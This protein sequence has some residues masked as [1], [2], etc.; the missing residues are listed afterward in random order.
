MSVEKLSSGSKL[1]DWALERHLVRYT[2][3]NKIFRIYFS[4]QQQIFE[5][6]QVYFT[7]KDFGE[8]TIS[9]PPPRKMISLETLSLSIR[10]PQIIEIK[11]NQESDS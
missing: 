1:L 2:D 10:Q 11:S 9:Y 7:C 8:A 5:T 3:Y 4:S 6:W